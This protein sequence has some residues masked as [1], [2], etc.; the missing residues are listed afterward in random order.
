MKVGRTVDTPAVY[1]HGGG[2][3]N[4]NQKPDWTSRRGTFALYFQKMPVCVKPTDY[5][6]PICRGRARVPGRLP[7]PH[8][9]LP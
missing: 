1:P 9:A 7:A 4:A 8:S 2:P 3:C 5:E 6:C